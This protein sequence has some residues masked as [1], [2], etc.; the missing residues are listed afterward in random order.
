MVMTLTKL[1]VLRRV[2]V[3]GLAGLGLLMLVATFTPVTRWYARALAGNWADAKGDVLIVL[4]A[5]TIDKSTL[6]PES[7]WRAVYAARAWREASFREVIVSGAWAA[8]LM[9]DFLVCHGVPES[10]IR[11]EQA[12]RSTRENA[13]Y[14][15]ALLGGGGGRTVLLTSDYHMFRARRA[16]EKAGVQVLPHPFPYALKHYNHIERRW[17]VFIGLAVES[18]KM[19]YYRLRGWI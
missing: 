2:V 14:V 6:D 13:L 3:A 19:C 12:S 5:G 15:K 8:P 16:F 4:G 17:P 11:I 1:T 7:Y 10:A 18:V 9:R